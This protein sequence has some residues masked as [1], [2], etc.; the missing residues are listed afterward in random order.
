MAFDLGTMRPVQTAHFVGDDGATWQFSTDLGTLQVGIPAPGTVRIALTPTAA[1]PHHTWSLNGTPPPAPKVQADGLVLRAEDGTS[2]TISESPLV[3]TLTDGDGRTI[4]QGSWLVAADGS[5]AANGTLGWRQDL[6]RAEAIFGGGL[7]TGALNRRG[8]RLTFWATDPEPDHGAQTDAMYQSIPFVMG[9]R[10]AGSSLAGAAYGVFF[11]QNAR[12][13]LDCGATDATALTYVT[14]G[15]DLVVYLFTGPALSDVLAR[16]TALTGRMPPVPRWSLGYQQSRWSYSSATEVREIA[17]AFRAHQIPCDAIYLDID[18]MRGFRD[19]TFDPE[20]FPDPPALISAL[21]SQGFQVVPIID[22]GIKVDPE[23]DVYAAGLEH[24]YFA[25]GA[26][27]Q[28][29]GGYVWPGRSVW[30]DFARPEVR[31]WWGEQHRVLL[32]AGVAGIWDDMNE[33]SQTNVSAPEQ[34][35]PFGA[36]LPLDAQFGPPDDPISHAQFHNAYGTEMVRATREGWERLQPER[37]AFVLT[38]AAGAGAQRFAAVWNGDNTSMWPHLRMAIPMNVGMSLSGFPMTGCDIGGFWKDTQPELLVRFTQLG[39]FLPFCRNHSALGTAHQEPWAFGE[40]YTSACRAAI[41]QRYR[42]LPY[43]VT[44][45]HQAS[46]TSAPIIRPLAWLTPDDANCVACD[47]EFLLGNDMLVAP[48]LEAGAVERH[49]LLPPGTWFARMATPNDSATL[50]DT[51]LR[52][53]GQVTVPVDLSTIPLFVRA[54]SILPTTAV[55]QHTGMAA[56]SLDWEVHL[57]APGTAASGTVWDDDDHPLAAARGTYAR[58]LATAHWDGDVITCEVTQTDGN[59][60]SRYPEMRW[61]LRLASGQR[62]V[63]IDP[64]SSA[65]LPFTCRFRVE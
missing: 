6:A 43:L 12:G 3:C 61:I 14:D 36:S 52:G 34:V 39:A 41:E 56:A 47:N 30:A 23:Y 55:V 45:A 9:L 7:R 5:P 22:P 19:F 40:P 25:R 63:A 59:M 58:Y 24:G 10:S 17:D 60:A 62:A 20:R 16:Y 33:P 57:A 64:V 42:L 8:R 26:D 38:R 46:E 13:L 35:I 48:V 37:R 2:I 51:V 4:V 28:P 29:Y 53:P 11:D 44:L 54:G 15:P 18:Y 65:T 21:Q 50:H 32:D 49:V 1:P 27:G 31:A